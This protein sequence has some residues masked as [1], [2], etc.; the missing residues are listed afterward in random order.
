VA[1]LDALAALTL[2]YELR[3]SGGAGGVRGP[4]AVWRALVAKGGSGAVD[5]R[6]RYTS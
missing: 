3:R 6:R 2:L 4:A 1:A 5:V